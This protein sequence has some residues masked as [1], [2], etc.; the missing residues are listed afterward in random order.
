MT[1]SERLKSIMAIDRDAVEVDYRGE[2]ITWGAIAQIVEGIESL[3]QAGRV[4]PAA[5]V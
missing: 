3:L 1:L 4:G 2:P 5:P